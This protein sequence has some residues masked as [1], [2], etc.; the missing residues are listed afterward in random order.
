MQN[1]CNELTKIKR[2]IVLLA[3]ITSFFPSFLDI[4]HLFR[5]SSRWTTDL[6]NYRGTSMH[7]EHF[8]TKLTIDKC[9]VSI[10]E[11]SGTIFPII[12]VGYVRYE[13]WRE[14][15]TFY[16]RRYGRTHRYEKSNFQPAATVQKIHFQ[17]VTSRSPTGLIDS[18]YVPLDISK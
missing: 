6:W 18:M 9:N 8:Q 17:H 3:F 11:K 7:V 16:A 15:K 2:K 13:Y 10:W 4:H 12:K 5:I 14:N 1:L